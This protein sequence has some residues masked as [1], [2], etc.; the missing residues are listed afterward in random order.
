MKDKCENCAF[1]YHIPAEGM[2]LRVDLE[3]AFKK[4]L[5]DKSFEVDPSD[6]Q[7][8]YS[9]TLGWAIAKGLSPKDA[10]KFSTHLRYHTELA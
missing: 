1:K 6:E 10:H 7:D 9:L 2:I 5:S 8:W 4:E 3:I